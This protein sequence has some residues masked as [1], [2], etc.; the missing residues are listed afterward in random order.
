MESVA[1]KIL[2]CEEIKPGVYKGCIVSLERLGELNR[3]IHGAMHKRREAVE[4]NLQ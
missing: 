4:K 3:G 1:E 2:D